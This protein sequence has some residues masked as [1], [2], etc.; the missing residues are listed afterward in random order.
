[1]A[2]SKR[3]SAQSKSKRQSTRFKVGQFSFTSGQP[4]AISPVAATDR[5]PKATASQ[6]KYATQI[7]SVIEAYLAAGHELLSGTYAGVKDLAPP[8][9]VN[10]SRTIVI[11]CNDGV[12]VRYESSPDDA[13]QV[14]ASH[15]NLSMAE[16]AHQVSES[17][18]FCVPPGA[19]KSSIATSAS[20]I[21]SLATYEPSTGNSTGIAEFRIAYRCTVEAGADSNVV[22]GRPARLIGVQSE[23]E[24][25]MLAEKA[26]EGQPRGQGRRFVTRSILS[27]PVGWEYI[28]IYSSADLKYWKKELARSW[29]ENDILVWVMRRQL[30]DQQFRALDPNVDARKYWARLLDEYEKLLNSDPQE[31]VLQEFLVKNPTLLSP[32][33]V[34]FWSK[35]SFGNRVSDFVFREAAGDYLLVEIE[36]PSKKLFIKTGDTSSALNHAQNQIADWKRYIEDNLNTVQTELGLDK[37]SP[38][39][40]SLIV[41]GRS[42][43]VS[44]E[45]RRKLGT[46][47]SDNPRQTIMTYDDLLDNAKAAIENV[48]GHLQAAGASTDVYFLR[49]HPS[50]PSP[51]PR[52][53]EG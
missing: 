51:L 18:I 1:M 25:Q 49:D 23:F 15:A 29:V 12:I 16:L 31:E 33:Y 48:L 37:M 35:V 46:M 47:R 41:I 45:G 3:S 28:E 50:P 43:T 4:L 40:K 8:H 38:N 42:N 27:L 13:D 26:D 11:C 20:P 2:S 30:R 32:T 34:R 21:V 10:S 14:I 24:L 36:R 44:E 17:V 19:E 7:A 6:K 22:G 53:G 52:A 5:A 9:L 39:P